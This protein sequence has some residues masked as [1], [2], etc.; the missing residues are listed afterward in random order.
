MSGEFGSDYVVLVDE[1]GAEQEFEHLVTLEYNG[2]T[3][4]AFIPVIDDPQAALDDTADLVILRAETDEKGEDFLSTIDD[5][6]EL[7]RVYGLFMERVEEYQDD[8]D[9]NEDDDSA[10]E[11]E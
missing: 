8:E 11:D 7:E 5:E 1:E 9:E 6:D 3:Y 2:N 10:P 4:M